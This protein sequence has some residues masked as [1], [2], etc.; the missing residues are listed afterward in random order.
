MSARAANVELRIDTPEGVPLQF[1]IASVGERV[2]AFLVDVLLL[3]LAWLLPTV[4]LWL[5]GAI[6]AWWISCSVLLGFVAWTC[7]FP[8]F[9]LRW[10]GATP[11][12]RRLQLRVVS[13]DGGPLTA[14]AVLARNFTRHFELV[15]PLAFLAAPAHIAPGHAA[16]LQWLAGAWLLLLLL[17][18]I[19]NRAR[20]RAGDFVAGTRVVLAP[21]LLLL[22][23]LARHRDSDAAAAAR[24]PFT[25]AQLEVYGIYELQV[26]EEVLRRA[27]EPGGG[28]AVTAVAER[29]KNKLGI[30]ARSLVGVPAIRFLHDFYTAQRSH[31][32][33]HLLLGRRRERRRAADPR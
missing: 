14:E 10:H 6:G 7:Y 12:K 3:L 8:F 26:L 13:A 24:L 33:Q 20:M 22:P 30:D 15:L 21:R 18:P 16:W 2:S 11:G 23:D 27:G 28:D 29:I 4:T 5:T 9:E 17:L 32:E 31:L 1:E 19:C 25:R